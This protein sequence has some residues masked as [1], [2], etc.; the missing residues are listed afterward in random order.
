MRLM[1]VLQGV[2]P[3]LGCTEPAAI[4]LAA[5]LAREAVGGEVRKVTVFCDVNVFKNSLRV[6]IPG[7]KGVRGA[8]I[9]AG[10]G[11]V[12]GDSQL[13]L[14]ILSKVTPEDVFAARELVARGLVN[15]SIGERERPGLYIEALVETDRG[16]G[17]AII[18]D[19]HT[20]VTA[21]QANGQPRPLPNWVGDGSKREAQGGEDLL[22]EMSLAEMVELAESMTAE[23]MTYLLKGV[24]MNEECLSFFFRIEPSTKIS[25]SP[26]QHRIL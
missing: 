22:K 20:N 16:A 8:P 23:E 19:T 17:R 14:E 7:L 25:S 9:A 21:V 24:R 26:F 11:A 15:V 2:Q 4:A 1:D 13:R 18:E 3:S 10:L 12:A 5:A 6:G